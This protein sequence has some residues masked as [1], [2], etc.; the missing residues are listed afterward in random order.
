MAIV[1][2]EYTDAITASDGSAWEA[3]ACARKAGAKW[4]GWIEFV[5]LT[6]GASPIRTPIETTQPNR[7]ALRQWASGLTPTYLDGGLK[8]A[9][10]RP[11]IV[12]GSPAP[13][14]F[15][16][17]APTIVRAEVSAAAS[18]TPLLD[19]YD[20]YAQGEQRLIDQLAALSIDH[21]RNIALAYEI[22]DPATAIASTRGELVAHI[23]ADA[24]ESAVRA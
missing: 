7:T 9:Q 6:A 17:P 4:E 13:A 19:P 16:N 15:A 11:A 18:P 14:L 10:S 5:P 22:V 2:T 12:V 3:R 21:V 20:V 23:L 1:I 8:R 24:R